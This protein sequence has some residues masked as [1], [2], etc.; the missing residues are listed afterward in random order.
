MTEAGASTLVVA[1]AILGDHGHDFREYAPDVVQRRFVEH[2]ASLP[3][4]TSDQLLERL[5]G[6]ASARERL[7]EALVVST[8]QFF[9]YVELFQVLREQVVARLG[10]AAIGPLRVWVAGAATGEEAWSMAMVLAEAEARGGAPWEV[11]ASDRSASS[12]A[13]ARL[14]RYDRVEAASIPSELR[15]EYTV[16][17]VDGFEVAPALRSRVRFCHHDLLGPSLAPP[18]AVLARFDLVLCCNVLIYLARHLQVR[19]IER[20]C[21][22]VA[23]GGA[24]ALGAHE[25]PAPGLA[26]R[27]RRFPGVAPAINLFAIAE[28]P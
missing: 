6:D 20:L 17:H 5:R 7:S 15:G 28:V 18:E 12:L 11:I 26:T 9:R 27:L 3:H 19:L 10:R 21:S 22:V 2:V 24:L 16:P 13:R 8:S 25:R 23:P 4:L 1:L 14:G